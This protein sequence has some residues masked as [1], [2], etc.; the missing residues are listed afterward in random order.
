MGATTMTQTE[1][2][3]HIGKD[4]S[5]VTRLKQA[6]RLVMDGGKVLVAE[7]LARI[8]AT[9]DPNRDD[10]ARRH[11]EE[12][13]A[14]AGCGEDGCRIQ[15]G[16]TGA[17]GGMTGSAGAFGDE[18]VTASYQQSRATKEH[19]LALQA[20]ANYEQEIGKLVLADEVRRAALDAGASLR[21]ALE[22]IPDQLAPQLTTMAD[23]EEIHALLAEYVEHAL[24]Q[25]AE[26][27][28]KM[29]APNG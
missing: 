3:A 15:S 13:A 7:S 21:T 29:A 18:R 14:K 22:G 16:M 10:V 28:A 19:Y 6:G 2:A 20:K 26:K 1:F 11:A 8:A 12:R 4:K 17:A 23:R 24:A 5:Y 27:M 9:K 25:A